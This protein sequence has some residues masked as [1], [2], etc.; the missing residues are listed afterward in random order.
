MMHV[1]EQHVKDL[2]R[3][4]GES[5]LDTQHW[6]SN[7]FTIY[8]FAV[9]R[10]CYAR[11]VAALFEEIDSF[12]WHTEAFS[13]S[14]FFFEDGQQDDETYYKLI[15]DVANSFPE[16]NERFWKSYK[17]VQDQIQE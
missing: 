8:G 13:P 16:Y 2:E 15:V 3:A 6:H 10:G 11:Y 12:G 7:P 9:A 14:L 17:V 1:N 4:C 5:L